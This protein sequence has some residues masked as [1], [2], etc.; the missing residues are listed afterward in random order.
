M[1][2]VLSLVRPED[3]VSQAYEALRAS[4][5]LTPRH[6]Q[7]ELSRKVSEAFE[8]SIP[9]VAEAPTGTGKTVG[10]L[11]GA[12]ASGDTTPIVVATATVGLQDQ[13]VR[14]DIPKLV[15]AGLIQ[16]HEVV[17]AKGRG[18]YFCREA[19]GKALR[20]TKV[21]QAGLFD[22]N[23]DAQEQ[24]ESAAALEQLSQLTSRYD[25]AT[26]N[27]DV[28]YWPGDK[29]VMWARVQANS[30]TCT[31]GKCPHYEGCAFFKA[32]KSLSSARVVV[33]NHDLVL[34]DLQQAAAEQETVLPFMT[35]RVVFDEA[36]HLPEKAMALGQGAA[37]LDELMTALQGVAAWAK[38]LHKTPA[39]LQAI[40]RATDDYGLLE[41]TVDA[42]Q[43]V[44][45]LQDLAQKLW[46]QKTDSVFTETTPA[47]LPEPW[48]APLGHLVRVFGALSENLGQA[49]SA[50]RSD[51]LEAKLPPKDKPELL[52]ALAGATGV[53]SQVREVADALR[54]FT[55]SNTDVRWWTVK[56]VASDEPTRVKLC[57]SP[58]EGSE[59]LTRMLWKSVRVRPVLVSATLRDFG[60]F[61]HFA[62]RSGLPAEH[63][64]CVV[65]PV[66]DYS[67]ATITVAKMGASPKQAERPAYMA[68]LS[69]KL[70]A[71][72]DAGAGSLVLLP[73]WA[74]LRQ[75]GPRIRSALGAD[76]VL[77]QGEQSIAML[78][79]MHRERIDKGL[80]S[81]LVGV[82]TMA[83]GLDLPG[84]Y[85]THVL[86]AALP[87]SVPTDPVE[88]RCQELL[89]SKYFG[90][91]ALP[92]A[93]VRL[94]QMTGRLMRR[95]SDH[96]RITVFDHRLGTTTYGRRMLA[97]LPPFKRG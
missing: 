10:Y 45:R 22:T 78:V 56:T 19:A 54:L 66:F 39:L 50:L 69:T 34:A 8:R 17:L 51:K 33:A 14:G 1:G 61:K 55:D 40:D 77:L 80:G 7:V 23:T 88:Q 65:A 3:P 72:I 31:K 26:W 67:R 47:E 89:G 48:R 90:E 81:V 73:S 9:L 28:D 43:T 92:D 44:K 68:E 25:D 37:T 75:L 64:E 79:E 32:R 5:K 20:E 35:Y 63:L 59:V 60:S 11:V 62:A 84:D 86:I 27:G 52:A 16:Q 4:S 29:P 12:L 58:L 85:C 36:H 91:K 93:L 13:I 6:Q 70:P 76:K 38:A 57:S 96:G 42:Q 74:M 82:A 24:V 87:F 49:L 18:R 41:N 97:A 21:G 83:E 2:A 15:K 53:A 94:V 95:E 71:A 30:D 46:P